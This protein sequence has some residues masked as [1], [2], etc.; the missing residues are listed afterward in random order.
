MTNFFRFPHTPHIA[1]LGDSEPRNDKVLTK[2]EIDTFLSNN[3]VLEE[4]VDGANLGFSL[5]SDGVVRAQNRGQY[6]T[7]PFLGQFSRLNQWLAIHEQSLFDVL[8]ESLM[9]FG[10]WTAAVHSLE[11]TNLPDY[12]LVFDVYDRHA[13]RFWSTPRRNALALQLGLR[14]I[15][16]IGRGSY[17]L[18]S[19][20]QIISMTPSVYRDGKCE[21]VYLRREDEDW[22]IARAKLVHPDF[23][24]DID[25]HWRSRSLR[26][27][28]LDIT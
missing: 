3:I 23:I 15:H 7:R 9:L 26:W 24:Q 19:L 14:P 10:E 11:Y 20:K 8:G 27:N 25:N 22:L 6:L 13:Q 17:Q 21:G 12:L 2:V 18:D 16:Q 1:W 5:G 28:T 4:K